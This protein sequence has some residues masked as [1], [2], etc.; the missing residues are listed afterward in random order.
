M[1]NAKSPELLLNLAACLPGSFELLASCTELR[2]VYVCSAK[3]RQG[4]GV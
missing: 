4:Y 2:T 3:Y 1:L